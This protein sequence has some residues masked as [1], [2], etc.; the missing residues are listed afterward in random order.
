MKRVILINPALDPEYR[1]IN[2]DYG[3]IPPPINLVCLASVVQDRAQVEI[4]D[5]NVKPVDWR[6]I[7]RASI[8]GITAMFISY[9]QALKIAAQYRKKFG[10]KCKIVLGGPHVTNMPV[11][12]LR[13]RPFVDY[14]VVGDGEPALRAL[15]SGKPPAKIPNIFYRQGG[16]IKF[17]CVAY[18]NLNKLPLL[19]LELISKGSL[20][21]YDPRYHGKK[22]K[23]LRPFPVAFTRGCGKSSRMGKCAYCTRPL[24][25]TSFM[26]PTRVWRQ[27][28]I[29]HRRYHI[30]YLKD[31][32]DDT[33]CGKFIYELAK[34]R[35]VGLGDLQME[36][37]AHPDDLTLPKVRA[38]KKV[39]VREVFIGIEHANRAM[40]KRANKGYDVSKVM[41]RLGLLC[42]QSIRFSPTFLFG[43]S[44]ETLKT[45]RQNLQM[46]RRIYQRFPGSVV[47]TF[48]AI[49]V[50]LP[51][52]AIFSQLLTCPRA[53]R[54]YNRAGGNLL[55][56]DVIDYRRLTELH[57]KYFTS[58]S[59]SQLSRFLNAGRDL[60]KSA[61]VAGFGRIE[62][63]GK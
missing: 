28:D 2:E 62:R 6:V 3:F 31:A 13:N 33:C 63:V 5:E 32:G 20:R 54:D 15:V 55:E 46:A 37:Y 9:K 42:Q 18:Q 56:D 7:K 51:G 61:P 52:S 34:S 38:M 58:V 22:I 1:F 53:V 43:L 35:P 30:N 12:V 49:V 11:R 16:E 24:R 19:P 8:V 39:G 44:G 4:I 50:P 14:V 17:S 27:I 29:L 41:S 45:A 48:F 26:R 40:L 21:R 47:Q 23:N 57:L 59:M 25:P 10:P 36:V 60:D